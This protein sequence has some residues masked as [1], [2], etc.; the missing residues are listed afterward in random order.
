MMVKICGITTVEDAQAAVDA[1]ASALGFNFYRVS[2]RYV[3]PEIAAG[4][5]QTVPANIC[6]V[7]V[8]VLRDES[9]RVEAGHTASTL[10]LDVVQ[11]HGPGH[12]PPGMRYWRAVAAGTALEDNGAEAF[13]VD[14][15]AGEQYGGTG[16]T[17]DWRIVREAKARII[18]AGGLDAS[19]V[20][21][22]IEAARPWGVD[23][24]SRIE[25]SPGRKDHQKMA[26]F[27]RAALA[28][29]S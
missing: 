20:A 13:L 26:A 18:V 11:I 6:K 4:I 17:F 15:P 3:A 23:A 16:R 21:Q 9:D 25:S 1:G 27:I 29:S 5:A 2:P 8:F 10:G 24:C 7:G 22:A 14:T 12:A 28:A 19:N